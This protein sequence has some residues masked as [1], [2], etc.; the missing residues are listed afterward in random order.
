M[1]SSDP[2]PSFAFWLTLC[3]VLAACSAEEDGGRPSS[4]QPGGSGGLGASAGA[5]AAR[6]SGAGTGGAAA[7]TASGV[8][9]MTGVAGAAGTAGASSMAGAGG[10][11][12]AAGGGPPPA[13]CGEAAR[14]YQLSVSSL[15]ASLVPYTGDRF[16]AGNTARAPVAVDPN[17]NKVY[18]GFTRAEGSSHSAVIAAEGSAPDAILSVPNAVLGAL[19]VTSDGVG[20]LI[21]DPNTMVDARVWAAVAR[22]TFDGSV[23]FNTDL[24]R[25]PN[26]EDVDTKGAPSAGRLGYLSQSDTLVAYFG[27]TQRY[28]DG[29][30]HQGG[31]LATLSAAGQQTVLNPWWGSHNL[32]QRMLIDGG[33]RAAVLGLGTMPAA[34]A[35][36]APT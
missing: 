6:G 23:A 2:R 33:A 24:F 20:A 10:A 5:A 4:M 8:A 31:Y 26:L 16:W 1:N 19:A 12:G 15:D 11:A 36:R 35:G 18:V 3:A 27:H 17:T 25:S 13:S 32:D 28:D 29:V 7:M 9:G 34:S 14:P 30:R 22:L 21:F